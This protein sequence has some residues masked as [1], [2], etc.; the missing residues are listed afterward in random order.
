[1]AAARQGCALSTGRRSIP[2]QYEDLKNGETNVSVLKDIIVGVLEE[3]G[4]TVDR[5]LLDFSVVSGG[6]TNKLFKCEAPNTSYTVRVYGGEG[7]INREVETETFIALADAKVGKEYIGE[8][9]NGRVEGWIDNA[10]AVDLKD[11]ASPEIFRLTAKE[12]A[13]RY[14]VVLLLLIFVSIVTTMLETVH[15]IHARHPAAF[16]ITERLFTG[17]FTAD[18]VIRASVARPDARSYCCSFFGIEAS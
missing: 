1:M 17:L 15:P 13:K 2:L 8:F 11:M 7:M 3:R 18:Y 10:D 9:G 16:A 6:I 12:L 5:S 14:D 4:K